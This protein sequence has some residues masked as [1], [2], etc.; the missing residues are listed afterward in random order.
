[1]YAACFVANNLPP[2][3]S[4]NK[5]SEPRQEVRKTDFAS[6]GNETPLAFYSKALA[7]LPPS[8]PYHPPC[9]FLFVF[10]TQTHTYTP[11][12]GAIVLSADAV[13]R[14]ALTGNAS[15]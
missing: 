3:V 5:P 11:I 2:Q 10:H 13:F 1:M 7:A 14:G 8:F 9:V 6:E 15:F 4:E 12:C